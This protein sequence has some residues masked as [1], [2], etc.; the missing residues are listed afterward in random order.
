[1]LDILEKNDIINTENS[2]IAYCR[3]RPCFY[4]QCNFEFC[5]A[6]PSFKK[7]YMIIARFKC[8]AFILLYNL[9]KIKLNSD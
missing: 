5:T 9:L 4:G 2:V 6:L 8:R 1:M 3:C 7:I